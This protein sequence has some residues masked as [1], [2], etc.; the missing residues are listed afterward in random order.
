LNN[1]ISLIKKYNK[2][3]G[4]KE[5]EKIKY[6]LEGIYLTFTKLVIISGFSILLGIFKE[7]LM[8]TIFYNIIRMFAFGLHAS[9]SYICLISSGIVFLALPYLATIINI[10][11]IIKIILS[12]LSLML[13]FLYAPADTNKRPLINK[14]KRLRLK[15]ASIIVTVIYIVIILID[16]NS[17]ISNIILLSLVTE[18]V[19]IL[20]LTYKIFKL[21]YRNYATYV[22]HYN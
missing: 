11:I 18:I 22:H 12:A 16:N 5:V 20:P 8:F 9:K 2:N 10:N 3:I 17:F 21:P 13:I 19:L 14:R 1:S 6:G 15:M 7:F 4:T